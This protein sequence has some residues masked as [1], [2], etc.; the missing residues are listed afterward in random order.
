MAS[1]NTLV[2]G[3]INRIAEIPSDIT[4]SPII[5][6]LID[7]ARK[8]VENITG[9]SISSTSIPNKF[10]NTLI[11]LGTA[12]TLSRIAGT[13]FDYS[14]SLGAWRVVKGGNSSLDS[15]VSFYLSLANLSLKHLSKF[16]VGGTFT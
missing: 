9:E 10:Q 1:V 12:Y 6:D 3:V 7:Y 2:S 11:N 8:D 14:Y 13:G 4:G 15:Q 5:Y 16:P